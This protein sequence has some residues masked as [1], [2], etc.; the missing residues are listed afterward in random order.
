M[1]ALDLIIKKRDGGQLTAEEISFLVQ[2]Y[3]RGEIPDYQ[4]AAFLMAVYLKGLDFSETRAFTRAFVESGE[5]LDLGDVPGIKVDK[6]STGGVGDKTTLV[7]VPLVAAA[8]VTVVKMSGRALGHTG[9]TL[10]KLESIPGFRVDL[11]LDEIKK[12]VRR[13]GAALTGQTANLVPADK[14]IYALRDATGTVDS[15]PLIASSVMS[16]KIA[17]GADRIVLDVKVGSGGFLPTL[18]QARALARLM[19]ALG[20][21]FGRRT[22]AVLSSME[23]PLGFAVGNALEVRE[24]ILTL[25]GEGPRDLVE[26]CLEL[27]GQMLHIAGVV[28]SPAAGRDKLEN[29]WRQGAGLAKMQEIIEAQGGSPRVVEDPFLLPRA[30]REIPVTAPAAGWIRAID[31]REIGWAALLLGAGRLC[32]EDRVDPAVGITLKKKAGDYVEPGEVLA[33]LHVNREDFLP[34]AESRVVGAFELDSVSSP[35]PAPLIYEVLT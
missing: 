15:L 34:E 5:V 25:Q 9:G 33:V 12:V 10:D 19:V 29:L 11:N 17:G 30:S 4:M 16:K 2:G 28:P 13:A 21:D 22:V 31:A 8:G 14:K 1:R 3:T 20:R 23:Q 24:A 7:L 35:T 26:L 32:K 6:H 27:G 18:E